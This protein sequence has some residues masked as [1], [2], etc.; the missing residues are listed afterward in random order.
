MACLQFLRIS[1]G[2]W[3]SLY[4]AQHRLWQAGTALPAIAQEP[5]VIC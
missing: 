5:G 4:S 2:S 3:L 1:D